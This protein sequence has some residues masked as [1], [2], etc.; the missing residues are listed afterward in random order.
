MYQMFY[1]EYPY[2]CEI[3]HLDESTNIS[4]EIVDAFDLIHPWRLDFM[5]KLLFLDAVDSGENMMTAEDI[6]KRHLLAFSDG[7]LEE[8]GQIGKKGFDKYVETFYGLWRHVNEIDANILE[9]WSFIP[10]DQ[11]YFP[12]DGAHRV[13]SAIKR[14]KKVKVYHIGFEAP[15]YCRYDFRYWRNQ[16]LE[17]HYILEM[18]KKYCSLRETQL[19]VFSN[20]Q[21]QICEDIYIQHLPVYMKEMEDYTIVVLDDEYL[22]GENRVFDCSICNE[23]HVGSVSVLRYLELHQQKLEKETIMMKCQKW[24]GRCYRWTRAQIWRKKD[25]LKKYIKNRF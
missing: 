6:Y 3:N 9:A 18:V 1:K 11:N 23:I 4:V 14:K 5:A 19:F 2:L 15:E 22:S 25:K 24:I 7:I 12:V 20:E 16:Y 17:E 21:S 13:T 8:K 10:V